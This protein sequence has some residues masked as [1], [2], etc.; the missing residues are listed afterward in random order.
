MKSVS[1][2]GCKDMENLNRIAFCTNQICEDYK[3]KI[4]SESEYMSKQTAVSFLVVEWQLAQLERN[5][6]WQ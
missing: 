4:P 1:L 3:T 2:L 5:A 6:M